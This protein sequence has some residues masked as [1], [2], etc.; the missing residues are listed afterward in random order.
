MRPL[1]EDNDRQQ[2]V[3]IV[4]EDQAVD[5]GDSSR[6]R[7]FMET[8]DIAAEKSL[9]AVDDAD[10]RSDR[11]NCEPEEDRVVKESDKRGQCAGEDVERLIVE[12]SVT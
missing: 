8:V 3:Q 12:V 5:C 1:I 11:G 7:V 9:S 2:S 10:V 4:D 6:K